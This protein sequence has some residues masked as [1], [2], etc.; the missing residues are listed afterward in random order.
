MAAFPA[1]VAPASSSAAFDKF[2]ATS[3]TTTLAPGDAIVFYTDGVTDVR[4]PHDLSP[5]DFSTLVGQVARDTVS[6]EDLADRLSKQLAALLPIED[7][8]DDI[9]L[10]IL[11]IPN[12]ADDDQALT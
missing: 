4:P 2:T 3:T 10:L 6:A 7:R 8:T 12:A 5:G 9:A 11:R 1:A